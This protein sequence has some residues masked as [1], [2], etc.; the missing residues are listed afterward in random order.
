MFLL[1][2]NKKVLSSR[3]FTWFN[4]NLT[5]KLKTG[6]NLVCSKNGSTGISKTVTEIVNAKELVAVF[7]E[8][9]MQMQVVNFNDGTNQIATFRWDNPGSTEW[10]RQLDLEVNFSTGLVSAKYTY[11]G[12]SMPSTLTLDKIMYR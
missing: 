2:Y 12:A 9:K 11:G 10:S 5:W 8:I 4:D 7:N 6:L 3:T 1:S